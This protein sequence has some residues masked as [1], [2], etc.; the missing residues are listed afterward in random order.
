MSKEALQRNLAKDSVSR[1]LE[2]GDDLSSHPYP[3][4][5][6]FETIGK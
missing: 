4:T 6:D 2:P 3:S 1:D 5:I